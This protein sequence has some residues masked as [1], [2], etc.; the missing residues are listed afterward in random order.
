M[1]AATSGGESMKWKRRILLTLGCLFL[2][3]AII[4]LG[5]SGI[6]SEFGM[7]GETLKYLAIAVGLV[8]ICLGLAYWGDD[9]RIV[10]PDPPVNRA[11]PKSI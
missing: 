8:A 3:A 6:Y 4:V 11:K 7:R 9:I 5:I 1:G 10:K 2:A